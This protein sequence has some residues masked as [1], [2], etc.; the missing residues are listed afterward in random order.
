MNERG[1]GLL[2]RNEQGVANRGGKG[3]I[4]RGDD[5]WN[6]DFVWDR[7]ATPSFYSSKGEAER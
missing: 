4:S 1:R 7:V 2:N 3:P 6:G 5:G